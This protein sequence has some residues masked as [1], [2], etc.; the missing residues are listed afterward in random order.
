MK[1]RLQALYGLK[2]DPFS[3]DVPVEAL[4]RSVAAESLCWRTEHVLLEEGGFAVVIGSPGTGKSVCLRLLEQHLTRSSSAKVVTLEHASGSISSFYRELGELFAVQLTPRNRW[5]GFK[6][7]RATWREH[8]ESTL[9]RPVLLVDEAQEMNPKVLT[10]LRILSSTRFDSRV[11]LSVVLAGDRRLHEKLRQEELAPLGSR[12]RI[13]LVLEP[14][15]KDA[16]AVI[17]DH[18]LKTAGANALLTPG[19]KT[20]LVER[21]AGNPRMLLAMGQELLVE[22]VRRELKQLDEKLFLEV[23]GSDEQRPK[24]RRRSA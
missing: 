24:R 14:M 11:I 7:L 13:R 5:G 21:S 15:D 12:L 16:L 3:G 20:T 17:L 6:A 23:F 22:A 19:L 1:H 4:H 10:E 9:L 8:V 18:R 2:W